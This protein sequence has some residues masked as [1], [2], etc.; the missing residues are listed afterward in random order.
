MVWYSEGSDL[1]NSALEDPGYPG[2]RLAEVKAMADLSD[3]VILAVGMDETMEGEEMNDQGFKGDKEDL[4]L[5]ECQRA[6]I[7]AVCERNTPVVLPC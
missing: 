5:P 4:Y 7:R 6:L 3:L 2:D 1:K